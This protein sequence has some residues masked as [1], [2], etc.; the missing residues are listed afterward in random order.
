M[1]DLEPLAVPE[2][3]PVSRGSLYGRIVM[4]GILGLL[5]VF[6]VLDYRAKSS[7]S[8]TATIWGDLV[9]REEMDNRLRKSNHAQYIDGTPTLAE[10]DVPNE[11]GGTD[12]I[13][14]YTWHGAI[15]NYV[16]KLSLA[17]GVDPMV[18][19]VE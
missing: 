7:A 19:K 13:L 2:E 1:S 14:E 9:V 6:G 3:I 17:N 4:Y 18:I 5:L 15:R 16:V 12:N 8:K 11:M 10:Y